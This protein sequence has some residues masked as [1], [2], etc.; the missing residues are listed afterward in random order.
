MEENDLQKRLFN[1]SVNIILAIRKLPNSSEYKVITYQLIKSSTSSA[2]NY[3]EAQAAVSRSDFSNK[4]GISLKE[5]RESNYWIRVINAIS[6]KSSEW[7]SFERESE[8][9][10]KILGSIYSKTSK[11]R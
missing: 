11:P 8:E 10:M 9:L 1:F 4:I 2:A 5:M 6:D 3:E 7:V